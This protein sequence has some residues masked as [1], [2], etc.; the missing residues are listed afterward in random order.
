MIVVR[1]VFKLK[2]GKARDAVAAMKEMLAEGSKTGA[3]PKSPRLMTDLVG[4]YYTLVLESSYANL[5]EYE[6]NLAGA[7]PTPAFQ[8]AYAKIVPFI[9]SGYREIFTLVA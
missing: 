8:A 9:E 5:A 7:M 2:F 4:E 3:G 6:A 1:D